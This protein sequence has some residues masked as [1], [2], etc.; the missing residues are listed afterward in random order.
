MKVL[1][2]TQSDFNW[3]VLGEGYCNECFECLLQNIENN[4]CD[5]EA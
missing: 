5:P 3:C 2:M 1:K 4:E